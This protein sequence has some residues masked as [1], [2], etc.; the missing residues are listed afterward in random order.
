MLDA[1]RPAKLQLATVRHLGAWR[2]ALKNLERVKMKHTTKIFVAKD[3]KELMGLLYG[4]ELKRIVWVQIQ[5][6]KILAGVN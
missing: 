6:N 5:K 4:Y 3:Q 2:L 1:G